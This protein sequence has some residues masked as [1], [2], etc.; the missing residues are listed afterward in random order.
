MKCK[1]CNGTGKIKEIDFTKPDWKDTE[2]VCPIC[3][4]S[5]VVKQTNFEIITENEE[6]LAKWLSDKIHFC[7][8]VSCDE[9]TANVSDDE[10]KDVTN[11]ELWSAWLKQPHTKG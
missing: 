8:F 2:K 5:G 7:K 1:V 11:A 10:C 6:T 3:C 4:G 9:C